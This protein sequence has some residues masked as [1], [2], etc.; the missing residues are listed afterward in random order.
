MVV[1]EVSSSAESKQL[2]EKNMDRSR[3]I[4]GDCGYINVC[5][6]LSTHVHICKHALLCHYVLY[7]V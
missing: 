7:V 6:N 1:L 2:I 3:T 4:I 5:F